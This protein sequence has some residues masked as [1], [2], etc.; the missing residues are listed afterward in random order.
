MS[1]MTIIALIVGLVVVIA[2]VGVVMIGGDDE[3]DD[4]NGDNGELSGTLKIAGS[5]TVLPIA[6]AAAEDFM[7]DNPKVT[8]DVSGGGSSV[9]VKSVGD[10]TADIGMASREL[11]SSEIADYPD[12][13]QHVVA[14]DGIGVIVHK[15]NPIGSLTM[16]QIKDIYLG[17]YTNWNDIL[18]VKF[19]ND[20]VV[21][22]RDS[23]S[24]TRATF[25]ELVL[26]DADPVNTMLE[27]SSNGE[28]HDTVKTTPGAIGYCGLGYV[29]SEIKGL[30][31][32]EAADSEAVEPSVD[33]V[34]DDSYPISRNL[35]MFTKGE[36]NKLAKAFLDFVKSSEGQ[37]I[38]E[39]EG[40]VP[41]ATSGGS[42]GLSGSITIAGSTTVLPIAAASAE[43]F[44]NLNSKVTIYVSGGG[45]SVGVRSVGQGTADIGM[46]SRELKSSEIADYP[47]LE[48]HVVAKDGI[49]VIIHKDNPVNNLTMDQIKGI[50][51]GTYT[52]WQEVGGADTTIVVIG[53]DS[54]S[55]TR[56]T[57]EELVMDDE[58]PVN[59]MQEMSSNGEV[60]DSVETTPGA[61]GYCG[62][63][64][65]D[66]VVKGVAVENSGDYVLPS[67]GTVLD[68]TYPIS[69]NLNMFTDGPAAGISKA[70]IE[71][72]Q[73]ADGQAI[74]ED[75]GFVPL[76]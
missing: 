33:T 1:K 53:R 64:Y 17:T 74:V 5:T 18:D 51:N 62:L 47:D 36:P 73:S 26:D 61:I 32:R 28:V 41:L 14:K 72:I 34:L 23:N 75:E 60:H 76:V 67:V 9:G 11:K 12:L 21:I 40:F 42:G 38:V 43:E 48:Q 52:N 24:G 44:M 49:A 65:V 68:G 57:F 46:A 39:D 31:V 13:V 69:R 30:K 45:S 29:D 35:N 16:E 2:V 71:W 25:E 58:D 15:D 10:G 8:V 63:G 56:A 37:D 54:N 70:F 3:D 50:Y 55:G 59:T 7:T 20:I 27:M 66:D 19:D 4:G 22:G 6:G